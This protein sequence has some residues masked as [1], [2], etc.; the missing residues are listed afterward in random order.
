MSYYTEEEKRYLRKLYGEAYL[1]GMSKLTDIEQLGEAVYDGNR[2]KPEYVL[3]PFE[4][5]A[6]GIEL[7]SPGILS[8]SS[9]RTKRI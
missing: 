6:V 9:V 3:T 1:S 8:D 2:L 7:R 4:S 5:A